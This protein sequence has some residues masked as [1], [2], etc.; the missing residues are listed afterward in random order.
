MLC[1]GN[2]S[3]KMCQEGHAVMGCEKQFLGL[4]VCAINGVISSKSLYLSKTARQ[5]LCCKFASI[6]Y[7][8]LLS[9]CW[10]I[11]FQRYFVANS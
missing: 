8:K 1:G 6:N 9:L 4:I 5:T 7:T 2:C 3:E 11:S 10:K